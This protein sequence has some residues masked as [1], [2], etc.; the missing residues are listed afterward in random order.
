MRKLKFDNPEELSKQITH[1]FEKIREENRP[2][3]LSGL[4]LF[5]GTTRQ[6]LWEYMEAVKTGGDSPKAQCGDLLVTAKAQI[7]CW[8]EEEL[9]TRSKPAGIQFALQ[10]GYAG[11]GTKTETK[12]EAEVK[13]KAEPREIK[14]TDEELLHQMDVLSERLKAI[15]QKESAANGDHV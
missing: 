2:P 3:T 12:V 13:Q 11:W 1:Y 14:L 5:L 10:N 15:R 4:A 6:R 8:L 7:E 9:V